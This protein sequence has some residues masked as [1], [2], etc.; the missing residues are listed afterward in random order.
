MIGIVGVFSS[1][2]FVFFVTLWFKLSELGFVGCM[3]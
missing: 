1:C 2:S 3:G